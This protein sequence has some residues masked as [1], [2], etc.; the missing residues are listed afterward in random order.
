MTKKESYSRHV[1]WWLKR[2]WKIAIFPKRFIV[3]PVVVKTW[4]FWYI[5]V[6]V[7]D[8]I[9]PRGNVAMKNVSSW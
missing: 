1:G 6:Q 9:D 3:F 8:D 2:L 4:K 5:G 7:Y